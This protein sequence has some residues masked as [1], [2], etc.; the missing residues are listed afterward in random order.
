[1]PRL[2]GIEVLKFIRSHPD[3]KH[4][5]VV[6]FSNSFMTNLVEAA[7][8]AGADQCLMKASTTPTQ[9]FAAID[10]AMAKSA[11][12][13]AASSAIDPAVPTVNP[14]I[15]P[16]PPPAAAMAPPAPPRVP[17]SPVPK[18]NAPS[19]P[20][21]PRP[22]PPSPAPPKETSP[23]HRG[24]AYYTAPERAASPIHAEADPEFQAQIRQLFHSSST[25]KLGSIRNLATSF[26]QGDSAMQQSTLLTELFRKI[27]SMTGNAA[28]AGCQQIAEFAST[29]EAL[30]QELLQQPAFV[31]ASTRRTV[32]KAVDFLELQFQS[33]GSLDA[34]SSFEEKVLVLEA[35][36]VSAKNIQQTLS[37]LACS[38]EMSVD[39]AEALG[40][41]ASGPYSLVVVPAE[42]PGIS[43]FELFAQ[44]QSLPGHAHTPAI[45]LTG[46]ENFSVHSNP[47]LLG[48]NDV[49]AKPHLG[50]ELIL[51]T[52]MGVQ[53]RSLT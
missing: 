17:A 32:A 35:D 39:A 47:E 34:E 5:P 9:L 15:R 43:G 36:P 10:K 38:T 12:R 28:L 14:L 46:F 41:M 19:P 49:L 45:F 44:M 53:R 24:T 1:M 22:A 25:S 3:V 6:V 4:L 23:P 50:I 33:T 29:F 37:Q 18:P 40:L 20:P 11:L 51:K 42:M 27:H 31:N 21:P 13:K 16:A 48:D 8:R 52:V 26:V 2:D 30:L 7:W